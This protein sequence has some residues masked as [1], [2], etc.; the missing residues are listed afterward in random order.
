M[1][2][3]PLIESSLFKHPLTATPYGVYT[4]VLYNKPTLILI[5][6]FGLYHWYKLIYSII[7]GY[8]K[9]L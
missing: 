9:F 2:I 1:L 7:I 4:T 8:S 5:K 3:D 6:I